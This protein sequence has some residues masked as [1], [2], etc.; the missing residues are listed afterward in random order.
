MKRNV[1]SS[2]IKR[3][4]HHFAVQNSKAITG[5]CSNRHVRRLHMLLKGMPVDQ[6]QQFASPQS[7]KLWPAKGMAFGSSSLLDHFQLFRKESSALQPDFVERSCTFHLAGYSPL[8]S[9]QT[10]SERPLHT[11]SLHTH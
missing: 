7:A 11:P 4:H 5:T 2:S 6:P 3:E 10:A 8:S 1:Q 9:A